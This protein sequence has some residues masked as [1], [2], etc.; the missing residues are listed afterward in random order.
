MRATLLH[1]PTAGTKTGK[2]EIVA[3]LRLADFD[4]RYVSTKEDDLVAALRKNADLIVVAGGDGTVSEAL[5]ILPDRK[6][7]VALIPL[8]TANNLARSL[9]IAGTPQ[10]LVETWKI[11]RSCPVDIGA[12]KAPRG[13]SLFLEA[14]GLGLLPEYLRMAAKRK[15]SEGADNLI[16][17]RTLLQKALKDAKPVGIDVSV[18]GKSVSGEFLGVEIMNTP[19]T[20]PG[21]PLAAK[22]HV[23]DRL[24]NVICFKADQR[25]ALIEW[26]D[27]PQGEPPPVTA[28][29]GAQVEVTWADIPSRLDDE[30]Y[31]NSDRK[32]IAEITCQA[33][34]VRILIPVKHPAQKA[35]VATK[36]A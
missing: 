35:H 13:T 23:G 22:A 30:V 36:S 4:V 17:G 10:E 12:V 34:Q 9:G 20:G 25:K 5:R 26:L 11:D 24:L 27:A 29:Q 33:E 14:F 2:D 28:R 6:M 18:D 15:K 21:L 8:G 16:K 3:A 19:F 31:D 7:P 32:Q 1:N